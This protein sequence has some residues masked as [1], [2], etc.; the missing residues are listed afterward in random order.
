MR[1]YKRETPSKLALN[2]IMFRALMNPH[3]LL[4]LLDKNWFLCFWMNPFF[5]KCFFYSVMD[6]LRWNGSNTLCHQEAALSVNQSNNAAFCR[7]CS[8]R[9]SF[10]AFNRSRYFASSGKSWILLSG[11]IVQY[12]LLFPY[13]CF[14]RLLKCD[15]TEI[16]LNTPAFIRAEG[17]IPRRSAS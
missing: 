4:P 16:F 9:I 2:G 6:F 14:P 17:F 10:P 12:R 8:Y 11:C 1:I 13:F 3:G 15:W 5:I 7:S